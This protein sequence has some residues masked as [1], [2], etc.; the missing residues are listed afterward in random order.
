[1]TVENEKMIRLGQMDSNEYVNILIGV[2][3]ERVIFRWAISLVFITM[4][5]KI[6]S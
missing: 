4:Q 3:L 2:I 1:M 6:Q 5:R